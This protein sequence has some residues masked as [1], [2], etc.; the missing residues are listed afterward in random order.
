[1]KGSSTWPGGLPRRLRQL[2]RAPSE[3]TPLFLDS[4]EQDGNWDTAPGHRETRNDKYFPSEGHVQFIQ[5]SPTSVISTDH[6]KRPHN[7]FFVLDLL[8][9][10]LNA[11]A[12]ML[13]KSG[14][15]SLPMDS[16][17]NWLW[18]LGVSIV[19]SKPPYSYSVFRNRLW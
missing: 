7:Y 13:S 9:Q 15:P 4:Q 11:A 6:H 19:P 14:Q 5:K 17:K 16:D 3:N 1:M 10:P 8:K 2:E 18:S 12:Q